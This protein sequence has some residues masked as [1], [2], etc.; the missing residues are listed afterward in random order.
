[1]TVHY[2]LRELLD[3][4]PLAFAQ[5]TKTVLH[6]T[7]FADSQAKSELKILKKIGNT[8]LDYFAKIKLVASFEI[9]KK[10]NCETPYF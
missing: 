9:E 6:E 7:S 10:G 8:F 1:M 4:R 2:K 3:L 5:M